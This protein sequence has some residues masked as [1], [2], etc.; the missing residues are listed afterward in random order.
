NPSLTR[1]SPAGRHRGGSTHQPS[2]LYGGGAD[3]HACAPAA[4]E[5]GSASPLLVGTSSSEASRTPRSSSPLHDEEQPTCGPC[6]ARLGPSEPRGPQTEP[7][8]DGT[9]SSCPRPSDLDPSVWLDAT[10]GR[11]GAL[12]EVTPCDVPSWRAGAATA[13]GLATAAGLTLTPAVLVI[14]PLVLVGAAVGGTTALWAVGRLGDDEEALEEGEK[15]EGG[16]GGYSGYR[17][18]SGEEFGRLFW[19]D[20]CAGEAAAVC[21]EGLGPNLSLD[22][23]LVANARTVCGE[24]LGPNLS[25]DEGLV[26]NAR[27]DAPVPPPP[28]PPTASPGLK[29][30]RSAPAA[31]SRAPKGGGRRRRE[32]TV[33]RRTG[34]AATLSSSMVERHYPP[35]ELC[36]AS[37]VRLPGISSEDFFSVFFADDAPYS[38]KD[39]QL[40]RG[41]VDIEY[42]PWTQVKGA[43]I[44]SRPARGDDQREDAHVQHPDQELL[45]TGV[46]QGDQGPAHYGPVAGRA[47]DRARDEPG[48][49]TLRRPFPRPGEVGHRVVVG[50]RRG[51]RWGRRRRAAAELQ[52]EHPRRGRDAQAVHVRVADSEEGGGDVRRR[53]RGVV[54]NGQG[55]PEGDRGAEAAAEESKRRARVVGGAAARPSLR[56]AR[57]EDPEA[58]SVRA[59]REAQ[60]AVRRD[61]RA[62]GRRGHREARRDRDSPGDYVG[63]RSFRRPHIVRPRPGVA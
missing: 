19:S 9:L 41:D 15:S 27:A 37:G 13:L 47:G 42:G 55:G 5:D 32:A 21:G 11:C 26:A 29:R 31:V 54:R 56:P 63:V 48:R 58:A 30:V 36:V 40:A 24:G 20:E 33:L 8:D 57:G 43:S 53:G 46:R 28:P 14:H 2:D 16:G 38:M 6:E 23:G 18:F 34:E 10:L 60:A 39:F 51:R 44:R 7:P 1:A 22:E 25:L 45:R 4:A 59:A 12:P 3:F 17:L 35:L 62:D 61:G 49:D 52:A 50:S